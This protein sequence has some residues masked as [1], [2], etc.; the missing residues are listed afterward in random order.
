MK[1]SEMKNAMSRKKTS[2]YELN[3]RLDFKKYMLWGRAGAVTELEDKSTGL[4]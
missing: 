2:F 4:I 1:I 3:N